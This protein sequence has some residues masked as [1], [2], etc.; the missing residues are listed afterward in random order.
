MVGHLTVKRKLIRVVRVDRGHELVKVDLFAAICVGSLEKLLDRFVGH[1]RVD[2][3]HNL[4]DLLQSDAVAVSIELVE[5]LLRALCGLLRIRL[6]RTGLVH[7]ERKDGHDNNHCKDEG[8]EV[9]QQ[10]SSIAVGGET[11]QPE[12]LGDYDANGF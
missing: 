3:P 10:R 5:D 1:V 4:R 6:G 2:L 9:H 7:M 11:A 8:A 12:E